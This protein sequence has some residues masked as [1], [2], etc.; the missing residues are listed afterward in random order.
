MGSAV[1]SVKDIEQRTM[2]H[3]SLSSRLAI[4]WELLEAWENVATFVEKGPQT[5]SSPS[6]S[7]KC[8]LAYTLNAPQFQSFTL[9]H[10]SLWIP[11]LFLPFLSIPRSPWGV[12]VHSHP[13]PSSFLVHSQ[14][15]GVGMRKGEKGGESVCMR[16]REGEGGGMECEG[17]E[18]VRER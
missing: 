7:L 1:F 8:K 3:A 6:S 15:S 16:Q 17:G 11:G 12:L 18:E 13:I 14:N 10:H 9:P 5:F 4:E 2:S